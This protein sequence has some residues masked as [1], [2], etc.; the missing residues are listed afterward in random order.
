MRLTSNLLT[1]DECKDILQNVFGDTSVELVDYDLKSFDEILGYLA[2]HFN[3]TITYKKDGV[4]QEIKLFLKM[5]PMINDKQNKFVKKMSIFGKEVKVYQ[6]LLKYF[7]ELLDEPF[8]PKFVY[9]KNYEKVVWE[10]MALKN[11][12]VLNTNRMNEEQC[13]SVLKS[14]AG[15]HGACLIFEEKQSVNGKVFRIDEYY[16]DEVEEKTFSYEEGHPRYEWLKTAS[17]SIADL[18][19]FFSD[20]SKTVEKFKRYIFNELRDYLKPS[21][22]YRNVLVHDDLHSNNIMF[23]E[24]NQSIIVDY[25]LTRYAPPVF[26]VLLFLYLNAGRTYLSNNKARLLKYYYTKLE[27]VLAK[28][29][30]KLEELISRENF[31]ESAEEYDLPALVE[32]CLYGTNVLISQKLSKELMSNE[33]NFAKFMYQDRASFITREFTSDTTF[34]DRFSEVL[35]PLFELFEKA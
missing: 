7:N 30:I 26:D 16:P 17:S 27:D 25:Q 8:A 18:A 19:T 24:N 31:A 4:I 6:N 35:I 34:R 28:H 32:A 14:L 12:K 15:L 22:K 5:V 29:N 23:N 20:S 13:L 21:K 11:F 3:L 1:C 2:E 33:E 10:N 9:Q